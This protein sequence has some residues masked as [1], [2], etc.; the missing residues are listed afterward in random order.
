MSTIIL[1]LAVI[2]FCYHFSAYVKFMCNPENRKE[3]KVPLIASGA[4]IIALGG[5]FGYVA[6]IFPTT[7][8]SVLCGAGSGVVILL[9]ILLYFQFIF[10]KQ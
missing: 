2:A 3:N 9:I 5:S 4:I 7:L 8:G 10:A 1:I 6:N